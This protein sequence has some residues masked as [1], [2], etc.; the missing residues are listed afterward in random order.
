MTGCVER[1]TPDSPRRL[2]RAALG[3]VGRNALAHVPA[4]AAPAAVALL[5][6]TF[7]QESAEAAHA[8]WRQ[9]AVA[10]R[11]RFPGLG[12]LMDGAREDELSY[13]TDRDTT[14][15]RAKPPLIRTEHR[16]P[17]NRWRA[18]RPRCPPVVQQRWAG[19]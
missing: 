3:Y 7:A 10:L 13:M 18:P 8:Q 14:C 9:V 15:F 2:S 19:R 4:K 17:D 11:E 1:R 6:T 16:R 12:D 5:R